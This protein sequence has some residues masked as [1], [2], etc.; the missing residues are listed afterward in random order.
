M[1][2]LST[3]C[4]QVPLPEREL[5]LAISALDDPVPGEVDIEPNRPGMTRALL[6]LSLLCRTLLLA[7]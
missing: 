6:L 4:P 3:A 2:R 1:P 7:R 5:L